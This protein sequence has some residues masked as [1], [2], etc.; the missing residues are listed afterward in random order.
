[1]GPLG[2]GSLQGLRGPW[3]SR[4]GGDALLYILMEESRRGMLHNLWQAPQCLSLLAS[5][6]RQKGGCLKDFPGGG[7]S[8]SRQVVRR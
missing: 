8:R 1:M 2:E 7:L 3:R 6:K 4:V 5:E